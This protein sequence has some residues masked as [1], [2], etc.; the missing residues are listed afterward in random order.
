MAVASEERYGYKY[1]KTR[2]D[3]SP[4][5]SPF[6]TKDNEWILTTIINIEKQWPVLCDVLGVPELKEDP[7]YNNAV[8]LREN[9][10]RAYLM[11]LF[12]KIY[13]TKTA[14]EWCALLKKADIVHDKLAHYKDMEK[15]EQAWANE[16]IHEVT[17]PNGNKSVLVRPSMRS[18]KMGIPEWKRGPMLGEHTEEILAELGYTPEQI[19]QLKERKAVTSMK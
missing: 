17:C 18:E 7:R 1:P 2:M 5:G 6:R 10:N 13:A 12:E 16:Y 11:T 19:A 15:S 8:G 4:T 14:D 9:E 3:S